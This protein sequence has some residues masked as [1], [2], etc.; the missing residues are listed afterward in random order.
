MK[1]ESLQ[2]LSGIV[3]EENR[4]AGRTGPAGASFQQLLNEAVA[5][6]VQP[7]SGLQGPAGSDLSVSSAVGASMPNETKAM[8]PMMGAL[9]GALGQLATLCAQAGQAPLDLN[10]LAQALGNLGQTADEI[11][12]HTQSL[13]ESHPARRLAEEARV[14]AY[15]ESVKWRRG[16]YL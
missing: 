11:V 2:N 8:P 5:A 15:V 3:Q 6:G 4:Q 14:L 9:D 13:A 10:A 1:I 7:E 16:D 12:R